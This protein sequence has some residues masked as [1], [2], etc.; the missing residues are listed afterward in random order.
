MYNS[1]AEKKKVYLR[2][3]PKCYFNIITFL[4]EEFADINAQQNVPSCKL[5]LKELYQ[6]I[7]VV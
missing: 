3:F 4:K 6:Y 1:T 5:N 7:S 2:L